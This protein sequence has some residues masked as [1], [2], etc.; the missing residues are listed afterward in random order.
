MKRLTTFFVMLFLISNIFA[1]APVKRNPVN[2]AS[3]SQTNK[4]IPP[5]RNVT[6]KPAYNNGELN[7]NGVTY[8]MVS[9][10]GGTFTMGAT[11]EMNDPWDDEK[12]THRVTVSSFSIGETEVTQALWK[13]VMGKNPSYVKGDNLP[14]DYVSWNDCQSFLSK[15]NDLTGKNFRL[16]TEAE[17][18]F[19]A[20]GGNNSNHTQ[21]SGSSNI[22][23]V[24]WYSDNSDHKTHSVAQ[25]KA[26]E[27]GLYDMSGNV[28]EWCNDYWGNYSGIA[29]TNPKGP[30]SGTYRVRRGGGWSGDARNCRSSTRNYF[31]PVHSDSFMG[32]RL[33][34]SE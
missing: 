5:K 16:P 15:L 10:A 27:L 18:E 21:Y 4:K 7:V 12:P 26:N 33:C 8:K 23:D 11:S 19:A 30:N 9:V 3:V 29:Q 34:L 17:W 1:Q 2:N 24:A 20:R 6:N 25:K 28:L 32:L 14:V 31:D 13:A 22:D